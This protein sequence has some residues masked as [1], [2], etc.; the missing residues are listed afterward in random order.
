MTDDTENIVHLHRHKMPHGCATEN[1]FCVRAGGY[2][3]DLFPHGKFG[4]LAFVSDSE[5]RN[6]GFA[7][8]LLGPGYLID[9]LRA[10]D[11]GEIASLV[12]GDTPG[13]AA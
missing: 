1:G 10:V 12:G 4:L 9:F 2:V 8:P 13:G 7:V 11:R 6:G 5:T 3:I